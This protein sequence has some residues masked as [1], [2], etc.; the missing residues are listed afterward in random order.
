MDEK[1]ALQTA[2][3]RY[4][5]ARFSEWVETYKQLQQKEGWQVEKL[6]QPGW[7]YSNEAYKTFPRYRIANDTLVEIERLVAD[8]SAS[9]NELKASLIEAAAKA[10]AKLELQ[11]TNRLAQE[12]LREETEDFRIYIET[13]MRNDLVSVEPLPRRRVLNAEESREIW[14]DLK[15]TWHIE[16]GYWFPLRNG[17]IPPHVLAFHTD[18]LQNIDGLKLI[19]KELEKR[20]V[21]TVFLLHEFG[22]PD[23]EIELGIFEPGYRDG[24]EQYSTSEQMDW[25]IYAS[26]ESSIT[27]CGQWLTEIFRKLHPECTERT[28]GGPY[29]TP[30]LRGTW[31][32]LS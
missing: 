29:S 30:D 22:D 3:R 23:Y 31:E 8:S 32:T 2:A 14:Q 11:L 18:Y 12:A 25:M 27:V 19:R 13:L 20:H 28:Y 7:S 6:F 4:C 9:L 1:T 21:S 5:Q 24:G 17:P 15:R 10:Q 16:E 26:H